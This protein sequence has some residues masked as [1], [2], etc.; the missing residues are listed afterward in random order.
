MDLA[1]AAAAIGAAQQAA[2]PLPGQHN[3][4]IAADAADANAV[5]D[6]I[7]IAAFAPVYEIDDLTAQAAIGVLPRLEPK[8][9]HTNIRALEEVLKERAEA[10]PSAQSANFGYRG[11]V[12]QPAEYA[13]RSPIPWID[14]PNPGPHRE[15]GL[16]AGPTRDAEATYLAE[17]V[18]YLNQMA[19]N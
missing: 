3:A 12:E 5:N 8:P 10:V 7:D 14:A 2:P 9:N 17:K 4:A 19:M 15:I 16:A 1:A 11:L 18:A 13:L 6:N